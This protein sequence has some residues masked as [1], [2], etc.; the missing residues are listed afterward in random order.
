MNRHRTRNGGRRFRLSFL[1][2]DL[3]GQSRRL[4]RFQ[5]CQAAGTVDAPGRG[6]TDRFLF[7]LW[8]FFGL[9]KPERVCV[10]FVPGA[11]PIVQRLILGSGRQVGS[12]EQWDSDGCQV[13]VEDA[14]HLDIV[15]FTPGDESVRSEWLVVGLGV[16]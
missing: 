3:C 15:H 8:L 4:I 1:L 11:S 9:Y 6:T 5:D 16:E 14:Q 10:K 13:V 7:L 2:L 12:V